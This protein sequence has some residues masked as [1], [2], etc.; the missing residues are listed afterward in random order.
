MAGGAVKA[1]GDF[2]G[3]SDMRNNDIILEAEGIYK[4]YRMWASEVPVLKGVDLSVKKG[5]FVAI[6]GA[7]GGG[8]STLLHILGALDKP[9]E[10]AVRF[11]GQD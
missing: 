6:V 8:K 5:E 11:K 2:T 7:S 10:G 3:E 4:S 9:D 1:G